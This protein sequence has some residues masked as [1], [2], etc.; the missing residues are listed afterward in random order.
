MTD[1]L[2]CRRPED[3][4][5]ATEGVIVASDD[6]GV[7]AA[8][9]A[10]G[11]TT[12]FLER[13]ESYLAI[14]EDLLTLLEQ[15][16]THL[17]ATTG[18]PLLFFELHAEGGLTS[19]RVQDVVLLIRAAERLYDAHRPKRVILR[20]R[21]VTQFEDDVLAAVA[22]SRGIQVIEHAGAGYR[23]AGRVKVYAKGGRV[24]PWRALWLRFWLQLVRNIAGARK[25]A[26]VATTRPV[27][28]QIES[29]ENKHVQNI[30]PVMKALEARGAR[31]VALCWRFPQVARALE[32]E[33]C[34]AEHLEAWL[35]PADAPRILGRWLK[36][37]RR[38]RKITANRFEYRGVDLMPLIRTSVEYLLGAQL[39]Q[40][41]ALDLASRRYIAERRPVAIKTWGDAIHEYGA[42]FTAAAR[43][44]SPAPLAF[45]F[46][47][48]AQFALPHS[49]ADLY[50]AAGENERADWIRAG[51]DPSR[52]VVTGPARYDGLRTNAVRT[53]EEA[54]ALLGIAE[55]QSPVILY[56]ADTPILGGTC[57]WEHVT[58][59]TELIDWFSKGGRGTLLIKPHPGDNTA[60]LERLRIERSSPHVGW[61]DRKSL[62]F[63]AIFASDAVLLK[64]STVGF[65]AMLLDRPVISLTLEGERRFQ[66]MFGPGAEKLSSLDDLFALL[67]R[68]SDDSVREEWSRERVEL[69]RAFLPSQYAHGGGASDRIA[70][71]V[72]A[73]LQE[74]PS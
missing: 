29:A 9:V 12:D 14:R 39:M 50:L 36:S 38:L 74:W 46:T 59:A 55:A 57:T 73:R 66:D 48:G 72:L 41:I 25:G 67:T 34:A 27:V 26:M 15:L 23:V 32:Q 6:A 35:S 24:A 20:R 54:R 2:I 58:V 7:H 44:T 11:L 28:F 19:Q 64:V 30:V 61:I 53:R 60:F 8:A 17:R 31:T 63:D 18:E 71:T 68:L 33:G 10:R 65:E 47:Q 49:S 69:S 51:V 70:E 37:F 13:T 40:R 42:I 4:A 56:C 45:Y 1:L 16:T 22:R 21:F 5:L 3:L 62:P 52:I 43:E